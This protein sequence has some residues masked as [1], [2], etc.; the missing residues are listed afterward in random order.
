MTIELLADNTDFLPTLV[1]WYECEW[2]PYYGADGRGNA[3]LDLASRC[4]RDTI[5]VGFVAKEN[6][7]LLG[8]TAL[9]R[10]PTTNLTPSVVG[11]LAAFAN[12]GHDHIYISTAILGDHLLRNGWR[13]IGDTRFLDDEHGSVYVF[14]STAPT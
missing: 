1:R 6:N 12:L 5:P 14:D 7:Q 3:E 9:D 8:V 11:L 2:G 10:D 13:R 4:N